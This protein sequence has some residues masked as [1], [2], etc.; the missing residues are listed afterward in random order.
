[1]ARYRYT[2]SEL[3]KAV[4]WTTGRGPVALLV[5]F[6]SPLSPRS[7]SSVSRPCEVAWVVQFSPLRTGAPTYFDWSASGWVVVGRGQ[8]R[9]LG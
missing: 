4:N 7:M 1:M 8:P 5:P 6:S 9:G 2:A 3:P